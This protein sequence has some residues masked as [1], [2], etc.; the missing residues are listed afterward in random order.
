MYVND[1]QIVKRES[2]RTSYR[3]WWVR[4]LTMR[5]LTVVWSF[6]VLLWTQFMPKYTWTV[7]LECAI[8][9]VLYV[10][11]CSSEQLLH[12][13]FNWLIYWL[14]SPLVLWNSIRTSKDRSCSTRCTSCAGRQQLDSATLCQAAAIVL[15]IELFSSYLCLNVVVYWRI[16]LI[17]NNNTILKKKPQI[18]SSMA[19]L[20][21]SL[22][23][24]IW[25]HRNFAQWQ[26]MGHQ[27]LLSVL[28]ILQ[29]AAAPRC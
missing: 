15:L 6:H 25:S 21:R 19:E 26:H 1:L 18:C 28:K 3:T 14:P 7:I 23:L 20:P 29:F 13:N 12:R 16:W 11:S 27:R 4:S 9:D 10:I 24:A 8:L 2:I 17:T 22:L 5:V